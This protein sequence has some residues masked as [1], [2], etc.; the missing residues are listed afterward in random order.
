MATETVTYRDG[1]VYELPEGSD[2]FERD[3]EGK[4]VSWRAPQ[5]TPQGEL[6]PSQVEGYQPRFARDGATRRVLGHVTD[7][8]HVGRGPRNT[9]ERL[10]RELMEDPF[11]PF[12][13]NDPDNILAHLQALQKAELVELREDGT[14][15]VTDAGRT[16]LHN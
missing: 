16:E 1:T 14:Y 8:E 4:P 7:E 13:K 12:E 15:G 2:V 9:P 11:S 6:H 5:V 10:A 3:P